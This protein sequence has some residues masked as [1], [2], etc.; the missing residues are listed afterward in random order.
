MRKRAAILALIGCALCAVLALERLARE[1]TYQGASLTQW[2]TAYRA[3][4]SNPG[5]N[6]NPEEWLPQLPDVPKSTVPE[7]KAP[8]E[9]VRA[10]RAR[11]LPY[12]ESWISFRPVPWR[13]CLLKHAAKLP[14]PLQ[15]S[16]VV[17]WLR[18]DRGYKRLDL[19]LSGFVILG[20]NSVPAIPTLAKVAADP[21]APGSIYA[22]RVLI[23]LGPP[24]VAA[25][26][27]LLTGPHS[28][29]VKDGVRMGL[30]RIGA[31][32][33]PA[34]P[35]LIRDLTGP[36]MMVA[37][38]SAAMLGQIGQQPEIVVPALIA[39]LDDQRFFIRQCSAAALGKFGEAAR[40]AVPRL[41]VLLSDMPLVEDAARRALTAI[42]PEVLTNASK[43]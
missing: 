38:R 34:I 26:T 21:T 31:G 43:Q 28:T 13:L 32:A 16:A 7:A 37:G 24:G 41:Q 9:A 18:P 5:I 25:L 20:P 6:F 30:G 8:A 35:A 2:L 10:M 27:N 17:N 22:I 39:A 3:C 15:K 36:D 1:P 11:A 42:A 29:G 4:I 19:A 23:E 14:A 12:L 40:P 33:S